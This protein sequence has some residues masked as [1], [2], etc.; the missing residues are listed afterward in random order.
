MRLIEKLIELAIRALLIA[1]FVALGSA[2]MRN[3]TDT[4]TIAVGHVPPG[5][6]YHAGTAAHDAN[7]HTQTGASVWRRMVP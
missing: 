2:I 5:M 4:F 3:L 7:L 6:A 1:V